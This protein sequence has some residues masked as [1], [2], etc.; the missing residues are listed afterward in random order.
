MVKEMVC[1]FRVSIVV[2]LYDQ[3]ESGEQPEL[4][5]A[6]AKSV[7]EAKVSGFKAVR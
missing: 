5:Q 7:E 1:M 2:P 6:Y 3:K 4:M